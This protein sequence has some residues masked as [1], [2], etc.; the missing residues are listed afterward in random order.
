LGDAKV[1]AA[2]TCVTLLQPGQRACL[3]A[4]DEGTLNVRLHELHAKR[5][6]VPALCEAALGVLALDAAGAA[7]DAVG[8]AV[9]AFATELIGICT[10]VPHC[11]HCP[12]RPAVAS[13]VRISLPQPGQ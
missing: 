5:I 12:F 13:G 8:E 1:D 7:G 2:G 6:C 10:F 9:S 3:P 11:G 4:F